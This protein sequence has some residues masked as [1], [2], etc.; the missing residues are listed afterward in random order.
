LGRHTLVTLFAY[1]SGP[2]TREQRLIVLVFLMRA[3]LPLVGVL[4]LGILCGCGGAKAR[5][6]THLAH[7]KELLA[8]GQLDKA[9]VEFRNALQIQPKSVEALYLQGQVEEKR[10]N[11]RQAAG[12]YL[13]AVDADGTYAPARAS[14]GKMYVFAGAP[15]KALEVLAPALTQEPDNPDLLAGRA[16]ARH[17]LKKDDPSVLSD[18]ERAVELVPTN[19]NAVAVRAALYAEQHDYVNAI[20]VA[21]TAVQKNPGSAELRELLTNLYLA[22]RQSKEAE[23]QMRRI[24]ELRPGELAPRL[25]LASYLRKSHD[26][27]GAQTVLE[28]AEKAS[29]TW[30]DATKVDQAR[31][32]LVDFIATERS[33]AQGEKLLRGFIAQQPDNYE[34]RF[35]LGSLLVRNGA[36]QEGISVFQEVIDRDHQGVHGL[37]A[38]DRIAAIRFQQGQFQQARTLVDE[39]LK[40]NPRDDDALILRGNLALGSNDATGAIG[41][42][43]A[44]L[45]DRPQSPVLQRS[46]AKAYLMK[47]QSGL[48]EEALRAALQQAPADTGARLD[49]ADQ[50]AAGGRLDQALTTLNDGVKAAP[51]SLALHVALI[52]AYLKKQD[53]A[54][55]R[56]AAE[57]LKATAPESPLGPYFLGLVALQMGKLD[58][59]ATQL[60]KA[61]AMKPGDLEILQALVRVDVTAG[62]PERSLVRARNA[63]AGAPKDPALVNFV[64]ELLL[65]SKDAG[66]AATEFNQAEALAPRWWVPHRNLANVKR[67]MGDWDGSLDEYRSALK[68]APLELALVSEAAA[69]L[70]Y[71]G[72]PDEAIDAYQALYKG[73]QA[74]RTVAANNLAMLLATYRT[75]QASLD[76]AR[77]LT[78]SFAASDN[79]SFLDT[80]GWVRFKRG[81]F[82]SAL[83]LLEKASG[84]SPASKVIRYHL[85]MTELRLGLKD[86]AKSN[87]ETVLSGP[88]EFAGAAD[89]KTAL[90]ALAPRS[91]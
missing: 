82:Q 7:G 86:R 6:Q 33:R 44:V 90:A 71:R 17:M 50:L 84:H 16:A 80:V 85:A 27:D 39:V 22:N 46:L 78:N 88:G 12:Y 74:V 36:T 13:A 41:D 28:E 83:P 8:A 73:N 37:S 38:R 58:E 51:R 65:R 61:L 56:A 91:G 62:K 57:D 63:L 3:R 70:E 79:D 34:L 54:A 45:R 40:N 14:M 42:F 9:G 29:H 49:L 11:P 30:K 48:A 52:R 35:G 32:A 43:R 89:A 18:S 59:S 64:G 77:D 67:F 81:E 31:L 1:C 72:H 25:Q 4:L 2:L 75:D 24:I 53:G 76:Q 23:E 26:L 15:Q 10:G 60:E 19:E 47:G 66:G 21:S 55:A 69:V 87:L 20:A 5:F 68:L